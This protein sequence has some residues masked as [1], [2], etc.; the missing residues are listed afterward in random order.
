MNY[1]STYE[2]FAIKYAKL[3]SVTLVPEVR[4]PEYKETEGGLTNGYCI[5]AGWVS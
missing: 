2:I 4:T 1:S 5:G 3:V